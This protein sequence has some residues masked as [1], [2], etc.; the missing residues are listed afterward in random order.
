MRTITAAS[1]ILLILLLTSCDNHNEFYYSYEDIT[2]K[3]ENTASRT[4]LY[5]MENGVA[6]DTVSV[7]YSGFTNS[8]FCTNLIFMD[9]GTVIIDDDCWNRTR[10]KPYK[11]KFISEYDTPEFF[12]SWT[13]SDGDIHTEHSIKHSRFI[14]NMRQSG[15]LYYICLTSM[16]T[17]QQ[18]NYDEETRRGYHTNVKAYRLK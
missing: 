4:Y 16:E 15:R 3:R 13:D 17:E 1:I 2:I 6:I 5:Y 18:H 7:Y 14:E 10:N 11:F 9:D 8:W 12:D